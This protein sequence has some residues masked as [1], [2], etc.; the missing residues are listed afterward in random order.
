[1]SFSRETEKKLKILLTQDRVENLEKS[2]S[3]ILIFNDKIH[4]KE[5]QPAVRKLL[6]QRATLKDF[7]TYIRKHYPS[8]LSQINMMFV[9][10]ARLVAAEKGIPDFP[11]ES[12]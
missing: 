9:E 6:C 8:Y 2:L 5:K 4:Q 12:V 7:R 3:K 10:K 1:M 11:N